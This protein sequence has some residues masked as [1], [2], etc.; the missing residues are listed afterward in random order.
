ML[1]RPILI[2]L[3]FILSENVSAQQAAVEQ[4]KG[5]DHIF[6]V[7]LTDGAG[8]SVADATLLLYRQTDS[9]LVKTAISNADGS[10]RF[11]DLMENKYFLKV[12]H[13]AY[14]DTTLFIN[15]IMAIAETLRI[16]LSQ[17]KG[18]KLEGVTI[19]SRK[20]LVERK[21]DRVVFNVENSVSV[22][23]SNALDALRKAPGV[24]VSGDNSIDMIGKGSV[25]V[26][27][28]NRLMQISAADLLNMLKTMPASDLSKIEVITN[29]PA[30]FDAAGN[31]GLINIITKKNRT[32]GVSGSIQGSYKQAVFPSYDGGG[33]LNY[34][35][36]K[37][38]VMATATAGRQMNY[39]VNG[40][41]IY[42]PS[43]TWIN[44]GESSSTTRQF[45]GSLGVDYELNNR[46]LLG[47]KYTTTQGKG[48][49]RSETSTEIFALKGLQPDSLIQTKNNTPANKQSHS[50]NM[51]F[52]HKFDSTGKKMTAAVDYFYYDKT[53]D[54]TFE[55]YNFFPHG[56]KT[57]DSALANS[58]AGQ[59]I[60]VYTGQLDVQLP[61]KW[62]DMS[63]GGKL[64]FIQ[65][66]NNTGYYNLSAGK[67]YY[68]S[69]RSNGFD[70]SERTQALYISANKHWKK[71]EWQA[72]LR[73]EFT[74]TRG[75]SQTYG[76][77]NNN[78]YFKLFPT[79]YMLYKHSEEHVYAF[80]YGRRIN[81][82]GYARLN[83]FRWYAS[84]FTYSEGNPFLQ[85][86]YSSNFEVRYDYKDWLSSQ[87]YLN[88]LSNGFDQIGI[89]DPATKI[90][91]IIQRN[92]LKGYNYGV[93]ESVNLTL[94]NWLESYNQVQVYHNLTVSSDPNTQDRISGWSAYL[95]TDNTIQCN[96]QG[97][98]QANIS[99]W[100]QF[101]EVDGVDRVGAYY[102][103]DIGTRVM[104][105]QK[106]LTLGVQAT[107][108]LKTNKVVIHSWTNGMQQVYDSYPGN[109]TV[110][111]SMAYR[112][113]K[114][115]KVKKQHE[116]N[117]E[118]KSR[119]N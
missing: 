75:F 93:I 56:G 104:L 7:R 4:K 8:Q 52:E 92:F 43:A 97:T 119:T 10:F 101:P 98:W 32:A 94:A 17:D 83:P 6:I 18:R 19:T 111:L 84:P 76:Q 40:S 21:I 45:S 58:Q 30:Q 1:T 23:G 11:T 112:L 90:T 59:K 117:T 73:G 87:I 36:G 25:Q 70:Y 60:H 62:I 89:P 74:Q 57:G 108:I 110:Q 103:L 63:F 2:C 15:S 85:P 100:Y 109:R 37:L 95:S 53:Q 88:I 106:R 105:F 65:N 38:S 113:G 12:S 69:S 27:I 71:F 33:T 54:Q 78:S 22:T 61:N 48:D 81:R 50:V 107:D 72:G 67:A 44:K 41:E 116:T 96:K 28:N 13:L 99:C 66:D 3:L 55:S 80:S 31:T 82:P 79:L 34:L 49:T 51:Y 114:K 46:Q 16:T 20:P 5:G 86:A 91:A 42:Y 115:G 118:E 14:K 35:Q 47:V 64:T 24:R 26:M 102:S 77:T 68:D 29:P 9:M 39:G